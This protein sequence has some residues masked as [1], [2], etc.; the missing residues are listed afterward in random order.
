MII[1]HSGNIVHNS[2]SHR[3]PIVMDCWYPEK[4]ANLP[5]V[6]FVH[7]FKGFKDWGHFHLLAQHFAHSGFAFLKMNFSHNGTTVEKPTEFDDIEAFGNNNFTHELNDL[8]DVINLIHNRKFELHDVIDTNKLFLLAHSRGGGIALI[9]ANEDSRIKA[10]ATLAS[11]N[12]LINLADEDI[13]RQWKKDG[14]R[15]IHNSRTN[16]NM[17]MYYQIAE[18][19]L[20]NADRINI[21]KAVMNL[22]DKQLI[23]HGTD[24]QTLP[25]TMANV[26]H[27]WNPKAKK[28][29]IDDA[30][31]TF[32]G[33]HPYEG[34]RLPVHARIAADEAI[35]FF[36]SKI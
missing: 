12:N 26:M 7:G 18:D 9:K 28:F 11:V 35:A 5:V 24:D 2:K 6:L 30:N 17:P 33:A 15:Y 4:T 32:G 20:A 31:H 34:N 8:G 27:F 29:I 1:I 36:K 16:Q 21:H 25:L 19:A 13:M 14:V 23:I 22:G 10:V 3:K